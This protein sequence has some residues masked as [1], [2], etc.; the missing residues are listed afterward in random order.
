[1]RKGDLLAFGEAGAA[2]ALIEPLPN[3]RD[4]RVLFVRGTDEH[5][6]GLEAPMSAELLSMAVPAEV[7]T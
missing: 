5:P 3:R 7:T 1:M 4:W 6:K 2:V